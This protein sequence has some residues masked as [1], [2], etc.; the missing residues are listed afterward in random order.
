LNLHFKKN[1][2]FTNFIRKCDKFCGEKIPNDSLGQWLQKKK[3]EE[4]QIAYVIG[5]WMKDG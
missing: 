1:Q 2:N 3:K 4:I 5:G